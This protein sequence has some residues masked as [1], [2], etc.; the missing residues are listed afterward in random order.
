VN[1]SSIGGFVG[2]PAAVIEDDAETAGAT[3]SRAA[4]VNHAQPGDPAR[5]AAAIEQIAS[6]GR[7]PL[8]VQLGRDSFSAIADKLAFVAGEQRTWHDLSVS[9]DHNDATSARTGSGREP[10]E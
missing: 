1:I 9:T 10:E 3:R 5:A 6:A 8:R 7:P 2:S 4:K